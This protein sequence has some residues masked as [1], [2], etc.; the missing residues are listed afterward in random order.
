MDY[1]Q[2]YEQLLVLLNKAEWPELLEKL[3]DDAV[4]ES[5]RRYRDASELAGN[6]ERSYYQD[7]VNQTP[8]ENAEHRERIR[9]AQWRQITCHMTLSELIYGH[10]DHADLRRYIKHHPYDDDEV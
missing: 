2:D 7:K 8:A 6:E 10:I 1:E 4:L 5:I 9:Q 3:P